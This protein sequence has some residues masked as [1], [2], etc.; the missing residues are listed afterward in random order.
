MISKRQKRR[1]AVAVLVAG[2]A[3][4]AVF[5]FTAFRKNMMY[6][7]TP[8]DIVEHHVADNAQLR[9]GGLVTPGSVKRGDGLQVDFTLADC[10]KSL[11]VRYEG[12][13]PDLFK[14]RSEEH[15]SELQSLMSISYAVF[16]L[17]KK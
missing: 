10:V 2:L 6:F 1:V 4:T 9:L 5:G 15:T 7:Y 16:C 13:L 12:I 17:K 3:L 8:T 11:P 14:E